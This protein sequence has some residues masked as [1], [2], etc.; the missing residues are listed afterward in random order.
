VQVGHQRPR[1]L[2]GEAEAPAQQVAR[3]VR[4]EAPVQQ[5]AQAVRGEAP[6]QRVAVAVVRGE[7]I[8]GDRPAHRQQG[9]GI[10]DEIRAVYVYYSTVLLVALNSRQNIFRYPSSRRRVSQ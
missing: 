4:G 8:P 1:R 7:V 3:V 5:L 9:D 6:A 2:A 10:W